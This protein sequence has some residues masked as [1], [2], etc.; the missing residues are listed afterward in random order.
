M[1]IYTILIII[2]LLYTLHL[3]YKIDMLANL[4]MKLVNI[5]E[6]AGRQEND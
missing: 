2:L 6:E 1:N 4:F 5:I 3:H